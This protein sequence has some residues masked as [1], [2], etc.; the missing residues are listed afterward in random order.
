ML[1]PRRD[2]LIEAAEAAPA[3]GPPA[4]GWGD[5]INVPR[6]RDRML[7]F[8]EREQLPGDVKQTLAAAL[9]GDLHLQHLLF[10]AMMDSWPKLQKNIGEIA[11]LVSIAPWKVVPHAARGKK[12]KP[13]AEKFAAEVED[14]IWCMKPRPA[15]GECGFEGTVKALATGF[16][17]GHAVSEIRW[18][19][20]AGGWRPR[21]TKPLP[22]RYYGY[23]FEEAPQD[24]PEDRLMLD[25]EGGTGS[26]NFVDFP[27][28][29]FLIGVNKGHP[30]HP[31]VAAPLRS[32]AAYWLAA[33][34]GLKWFMS[35]TQLYG[36]PWRHAE[37]ASAAD[38]NAVKSALASIGSNGYIVT[39]PG[40]KINIL[41]GGA[42]SGQSLPQRELIELADK[43]CDVFILG[44]TLTSGTDG[45]GS[46]ALGEVHQETKHGNVDAVADFVGE[47]LT[48]Q[49]VPAIVA[50]NWGERHDELPQIWA[51]REE[52]KDE[53]AAAERMEIVQRMGVPM[54]KQFVY[55]D[56]GIP[57]PAEGEELFQ[58]VADGAG[59]GGD[60]ETGERDEKGKQV[61][62]ADAGGGA[63][64]F[65]PKSGT[66][67]IPRVEMPQI[68][69]GN[70]GAM[71][72]FLRARGIESRQEE[73]AAASLKPTQ[74]EYF[75]EKVAAAKVHKGG[76]RAILISEDDHVVDGHHQW[77]AAREEG[78]TLRVI[79]L[80][81]PIHRVLMMAHRMPSTRVAAADASQPLTVDQL[82]DAVLEGLTGVTREWLS[83][84]RPAFERL[85]ALAMA[86]Q[87]T[88]EDFLAAL[89]KARRELPELFEVL[90]AGAL[91]EAFGEAIGSAMLAGSVSR[92]ER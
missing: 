22:A 58:P 63:E 6:A 88:D 89:E 34:Y 17:F 1:P 83:P 54:S 80:M 53:K 43:Q 70:R 29:R 8:F 21:A 67:G 23:P 24:D 41:D 13:G 49:L 45:S 4:G 87:V 9:N 57:M 59:K 61:S 55:D 79:R 12:P 27:Q 32:L 77:L 38:D 30:G 44:Q 20:A 91:E 73:V 48:H 15:R 74:L 90:D 76:N 52:T 37:V 68:D 51:K 46:R 3:P 82:S 42:T 31:A 56:L 39:R 50:V 62:A 2:S 25:P 92:Y 71:V 40:T 10:V 85:A 19:A 84:V 69:S 66:L 26:R 33:V 65:G 5:S 14:F 47:I 75:P 86:K 18:E 72:G 60:N 11:R 78:E 81:A 16:Y 28:H 36:I 64:R 35:F 7:E